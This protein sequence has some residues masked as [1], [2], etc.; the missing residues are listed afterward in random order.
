T[1]NTHTHTH[2]HSFIHRCTYCNC[3][4]H[5]HHCTTTNR[6]QCGKRAGAVAV[7][8]ITALRLALTPSCS[9]EMHKEKNEKKSKGK[10]RTRKTTKISQTVT[11]R[12]A[13]TGAV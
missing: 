8:P 2:T 13:N 7:C 9:K 11:N 4:H 12:Y 10:D 5:T 1:N 6:P 3:L